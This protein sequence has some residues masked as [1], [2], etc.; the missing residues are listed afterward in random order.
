MR[1]YLEAVSTKNRS[2]V[3]FQFQF[4]RR[5]EVQDPV[6]KWP[7]RRAGPI[8]KRKAHLRQDK[9]KSNKSNNKKESNNRKKEKPTWGSDKRS[10]LGARGR[11]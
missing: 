11:T 9:T 7:V 6:R 8:R 4:T 5:V 3:Q 1:G 2:P 10:P